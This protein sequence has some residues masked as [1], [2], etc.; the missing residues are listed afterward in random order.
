MSTQKP[1]RGFSFGLYGWVTRLA[2]PLA[3]LYLTWRARKQPAYSEHWDERFGWK[4]FPAPRPDSPRLWLHAVSLGETIAARPLIEAFLEAYPDSHVLLTCMT[5]TGRDAGARIAQAHPG[6]IEQCYLPYDTPD[7]AAKFFKETAPKLGVVMETEVWPN[8]VCQARDRGIGVVLANA[9]ESEKS[10]RAAGRFISVMRPAFASFAAV[11]AQSE[12]DRQRLESLGARNVRVCGSMKFDLKAD[13]GQ[14]ARAH[15]VKRRLGRPVVL[16][17]STREG[18]EAMFADGIRAMAGD[19]LVV[20]VPRHPQRFEAVAELMA[21]HGIA[22]VRKS[23]DTELAGV[24]DG[25]RLVL[26][27]TMGEMGFYCALADVCLMGGSF[28]GTGCQNLIEPA[29]AGSPV[30]L[31]PSTFNFAKAAHDAIAMGAAEPVDDAAQGFAKALAWLADG[32]LAQRR[33]A[34][35]RFARAYTGATARHMEVIG[36]LWSKANDNQPLPGGEK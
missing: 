13:A 18:E 4:R 28:G 10:A 29:A 20:L 16:I 19:A 23:R 21:G 5:P 7:L 3:S 17:A 31:G 25:T 2:L 15:E 27:D 12:E 1:G 32:T 24:V 8:I 30:I 34:A 26:G 36:A 9:R 14:V 33:Q 6:R 11:L 35:L 22:M